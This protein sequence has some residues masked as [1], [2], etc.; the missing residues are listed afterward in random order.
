MK[1][2]LLAAGKSTRTY[3]LTASKPKPLLKAANKTIIEHNLEQLQDLVD[4]VIIVIGFKGEIIRQKIGDKFQK[5]KITY[6]EQKEQAGSGHAL[7]QARDLVNEKFIV[8]NCDDFYSGKDIAKCIMH[9]YCLLVKETNDLSRFGEV[10]VKGN[11]VADFRE[12]PGKKPGLANTGVYVFKKDIFN[13]KLKKS[14]RQEYEIVDFV[15]YL[16]KEG[17]KVNYEIVSDYW[18]PITYPWNLLEANEFFLSRIIISNRGIIE[19]G[20]TLK[21][22]IAIGKDTL[23]KAG[24]YIEGPVVIGDNCSIGPNCFIR[25]STTIGNNSK[26]GNAVEIKNSIIGDNTSIGHLS[27][28]GDSVIGD[29]VNLGAGTITANLRHDDSTIST[30]VKGSMIDTGRR[31]HGAIIGDNV[32]TGINTSIYPGRKMWP[33][34]TTLPGEIVKKD[35]E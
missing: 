15:N 14:E 22:N 24:A 28:V 1:A 20:A 33:H 16:I 30:P 21:G 31:K 23:I 18:L 6:I 5:L 8:M 4:E 26:I 17:E 7:L 25:G 29:N 12:K 9:D 11:E 34:K 13:F 3:P 10:I 27:Y 35:I 32:H 19:K 2:I